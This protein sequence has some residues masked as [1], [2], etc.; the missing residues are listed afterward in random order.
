MAT[1]V[2]INEGAN[3]RL[4]ELQARL[5]LLIHKRVSKKDLL[6]LVLEVE[7]DVDRLAARV[8]G[9]RYPLPKAA[10]RRVR[11]RIIDWGVETREEDI[12]RVLYGWEK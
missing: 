4:N 9:L 11:S 5:L 10:R 8:L 2:H 6:E 7:P 12:N 1:T 3:R